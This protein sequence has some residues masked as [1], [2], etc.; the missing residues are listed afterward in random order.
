[1]PGIDR[2]E[3]LVNEAYG[4]KLT[5]ESVRKL[6]GK[7]CRLLGCG[8]EQADSLTMRQAV[9]IIETEGRVQN[10]EPQRQSSKAEINPMDVLLTWSGTTS[11]ELAAF[12]HDWLPQV[13]PGIRPWISS[14]DIAKGQRWFDELTNQMSKTNISITFITPG[15]VRSPWV[16]YEVGVIAAKMEQGSV[17]PYLIGVKGEQ[18][19]DTPIGQYQWTTATKNDTLKLL[20]S[21][22]KKLG[23]KG[24]DQG[25]IEGN[26]KTHWPKLNRRLEKLAEES[27][28]IS[29]LVVE[30]EP[31]VEESLSSEARQLLLK[32]SSD[33]GCRLM[34]REYDEEPILSFGDDNL[35][36]EGSLRTIATW[37]AALQEL[38]SLGLIADL[39]YEGQ[40]FNLT[41]EG[42]RIADLI[43]SRDQ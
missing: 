1:M 10:A 32:A 15:N 21:I 31:S 23:D 11:H 17:C 25:L 9:E 20:Q 36:A 14:Q 6:R 27:P 5:S 12:F 38:E 41:R 24:H 19:K 3:A 13:L 18:V 40:M 30:T 28:P 37:K 42:Y 16:F 29:S 26:F 4:T 7:V 33:G 35:I 22:N 39:G 43:V 8:T 34:F 2:L